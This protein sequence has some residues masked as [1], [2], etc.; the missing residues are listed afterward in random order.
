MGKHNERVRRLHHLLE[1]ALQIFGILGWLCLVLY[2]M[3]GDE[4]DRSLAAFVAGSILVAALVPGTCVS[5][6]D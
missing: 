5:L 2:G 4:E 1:W 6:V 3:G